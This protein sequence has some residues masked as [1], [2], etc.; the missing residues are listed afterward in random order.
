[1]NKNIHFDLVLVF[2]DLKI[3]FTRPQNKG[4]IYDTRAYMYVT[5]TKYICEG[6]LKRQNKIDE[7]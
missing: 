2:L 1:M 7:L 5:S 6:R 3:D 4:N